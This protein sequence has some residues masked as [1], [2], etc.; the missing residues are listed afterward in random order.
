[1]RLA[2][3]YGARYK[4]DEPLKKEKSTVRLRR[5]KEKVVVAPLFDAPEPVYVNGTVHTLTHT[6]YKNHKIKLEPNQSIDNALKFINSFGWTMLVNQ[7]K[8]NEVQVLLSRLKPDGSVDTVEKISNSLVLA[9][10]SALDAVMD[11]SFKV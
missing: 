8:N 11:R 7:F 3:N 10:F 1:M 4:K 9:V 6:I 5:K 2:K